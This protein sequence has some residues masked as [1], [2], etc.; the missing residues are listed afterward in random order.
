MIAM[1][2]ETKKKT[3]AE[4]RKEECERITSELE[5][6]GYRCEN[7]TISI[8]KANLMVFAT[9]VPVCVFFAVIYALANGG[10]S[11]LSEANGWALFP[12]LVLLSIPVHE[13]LHGLGWL[14]S[15]KNGW[16]SIRFGMMWSSLTPYCNCKEPMGVKNYYLG[17]LMPFTVLGLLPSAAAIP[18]GSMTMLAFG[19][20][21]ILFAGGDLTIALVIRKYI[22]KQAVLLDHPSECGSL[23]FIREA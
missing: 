23:A 18:A 9:S 4:V 11:R 7:A 12:I 5:Q 22:G 1:E 10:Y 20:M 17:L 19:L 2:Q 21:N 8:L 3:A 16:K 13:L 6:Q 14:P 15:C